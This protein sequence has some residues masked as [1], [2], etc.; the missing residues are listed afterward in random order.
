MFTNSKKDCG[1]KK[2]SLIPKY[3]RIPKN[4][5]IP[6]LFMYSKDDH[7]FKNFTHSKQV[8]AFKK[9][10]WIQKTI[11]IYK[12]TWIRKI[13]ASNSKYVHELRLL[14]LATHHLQLSLLMA[15]EVAHFY[16]LTAM[17]IAPLFPR[18]LLIPYRNMWW[19]RGMMFLPTST[20]GISFAF[21]IMLVSS[22]VSGST[23]VRLMVLLSITKLV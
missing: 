21:L 14:L 11:H 16:L 1:C 22:L 8:R 4:L 12:N 13:F 10:T 17:V 9:C 19:H 7:I 20:R 2:C 5:W 18:R 6:K 15:S 3:S 23:S